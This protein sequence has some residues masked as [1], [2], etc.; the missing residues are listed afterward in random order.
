MSYQAITTVT[1]EVAGQQERNI[2][3]SDRVDTAHVQV[4][5]DGLWVTAIDREAVAAHAYAW[6]A[7]TVEAPSM[8]PPE[9][10]ITG[11][12]RRMIAT[13]IL[14][15]SGFVQ[16]NVY[17]IK[18]DGKEPAYLEVV[19]GALRVRAF[20]QAAVLDHRGR[21]GTRAGDRVHDLDAHADD[22]RPERGRHSHGAPRKA[23][24][25]PGRS[26]AGPV[27]PRRWGSYHLVRA[28]PVV[29]HMPPASIPK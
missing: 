21:V 9:A 18:A 13:T 11:I 10:H 26:A 23:R 5:L 25:R 16:P 1:A 15:Q 14:R 27:T 20:D 4:Q 3:S 12:P 8:L 2:L 29:I 7:A 22:D 6:N 28:P 24:D 17:R 19:V